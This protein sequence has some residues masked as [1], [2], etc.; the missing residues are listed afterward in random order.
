MSNHFHKDILIISFP[1]FLR[2]HSVLKYPFHIDVRRLVPLT[3]H[4]T[5][6]LYSVK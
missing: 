6:A 5:T 3:S 2:H 4:N 1:S